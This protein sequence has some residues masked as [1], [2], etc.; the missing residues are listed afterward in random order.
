MGAWMGDPED[1]LAVSLA[2]GGETDLLLS[3]L[4]ASQDCVKLLE[5]DGTLA[6]MS[7]NG[8]RAMEVDSFDSI[9]G[10][11]WPVLWPAAAHGRLQEALSRARAGQKSSFEAACPTA[12]GAPRWWHVSVIPIRSASGALH[13]ILAASRDITER[14]L[15]EQAQQEHAASLEQAL[16]EKSD[17]LAQRDFLMREVDHRVK[18]SLAQVSAILRLQARRAPPDVRRALEEA[19]QRVAAI[20]RVHEQLQSSDDLRSIPVLPLLE[21]LCAEFALSLDRVIT[22]AP[23]EGTERM[24]MP[25]ERA[26]ALSII[27]GE[28]VANAVRHGT[29]TGPVIVRLSRTSPATARLSVVNAASGP[30]PTVQT[31][32]QGLG[33]TICQTYAATL[34][35]QLDWHFAAGHLT[36]TL[37]FTP[38]KN[39]CLR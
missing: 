7:V 24:V 38:G 13:K 27:L 10:R 35:G 33:T 34:D 39:D 28:L 3:L 23:E 20:A 5:P 21:R 30:R 26:S 12:R 37:D 19:A 18:N 17:L 8:M 29:G 11:P 16:A 6:F 9:A 2:G 22:L 1:H 36:A 32:R 31:G 4:A 25:S 15:R 14:V